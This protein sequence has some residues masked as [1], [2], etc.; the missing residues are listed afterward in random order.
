MASRFIPLHILKR[1]DRVAQAHLCHT[2]G[3]S[4]IPPLSGV[5]TRTAAAVTLGDIFVSRWG[6]DQTN[7]D[8]YQVV[9][10]TKTMVMLRPVAK[11]LV[12]GRG[13][14]TEYVVPLANNFTGPVLRKKLKEHWRGGPWVDLNSYSGASKWDGKEVGQTGGAYGR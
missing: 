1:I 3:Q 5:V 6:Y 4:F 8:F 2:T 12:R 11:R 7:V 13:E 10:T 9:G 14:P